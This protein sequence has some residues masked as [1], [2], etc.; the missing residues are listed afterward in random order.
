MKRRTAL[1]AMTAGSLCACAATQATRPPADRPMLVL[2]HGAWHGAWCWERVLPLL[3]EDGWKAVALTLPGLAE[4]HGELSTAIDLEAHVAAVVQAADRL[5]V[6]V[7]LVGHSYGGF[8]V[9]GAADRLAPSGRL[10][11][12]V[13]LDAF[14]PR[15]GEKTADYMAPEARA[16]LQAAFARGDAAY[17]PPPVRFFGV[18]E[19][20][21]AAWAQARVSPQPAGTYLQPLKLS[22]EL[23]ATVKKDYIACQSPRLPVFDETKVR[24][25]NDPRWTYRELQTGHD[26]MIITP[27]ELASMIGAVA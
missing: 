4:D 10:R 17:K 6:P 20:A 15:N 18:Q 14:V 16:A 22:G 3:Q 7:A 24:I 25:R 13:Y 5:G 19:P 2:V 9:T 26:A 12:V 27:R 21:D 23:P 8:V 1:G 11:S